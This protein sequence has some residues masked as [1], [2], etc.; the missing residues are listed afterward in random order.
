MELDEDMEDMD[1]PS[2]ARDLAQ[3]ALQF[4]QALQAEYAQD[5]RKEVRAALKDIFGL[6]AYQN[7][8]K[9]SKL[10][11]LLDRKG[12][13]AVAEE[14]NSAILRE[15]SRCTPDHHRRL[16]SEMDFMTDPFGQILLASHHGPHWRMSTR[17]HRC[18]S[19]T[20][21][22][23]AAQAPSSR[24]RALST[25]SR[26]LVNDCRRSRSTTA[27]STRD[28]PLERQPSGCRYGRDRL[29]GLWKLRSLCLKPRADPF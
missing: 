1:T 11:Y 29:Q 4:G 19:T 28:T 5:E 26:C 14:L 25:T 16:G 8:L 24:C 23:R 6:M 10:S 13:V 15:S 7:P 21:P 3:D 17:R 9:E 2:D 18:S 12:R 22:K 27:L 20:W